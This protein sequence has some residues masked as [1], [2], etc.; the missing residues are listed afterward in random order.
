[1]VVGSTAFGPL[2][3]TKILSLPLGWKIP[4]PCARHIWPQITTTLG[5][6]FWLTT[7]GV[8]SSPGTTSLYG[9]VAML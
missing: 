7:P 1:L 2:P 8:K 3:P 5:S 6:F 9:T 4:T